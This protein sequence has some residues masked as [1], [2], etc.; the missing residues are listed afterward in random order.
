MWISIFM[1]R[2]VM[3]SFKGKHCSFFNEIQSGHPNNAFCHWNLEFL[4]TRF[5]FMD[6]FLR[7]MS[8]VKNRFQPPTTPVFAAPYHGV[9]YLHESRRY[10]TA[11]SVYTN[12]WPVTQRNHVLD[13]GLGKYPWKEWTRSLLELC[14]C[15][16]LP[17]RDPKAERIMAFSATEPNTKNSLTRLPTPGPAKSTKTSRVLTRL[18]YTARRWYTAFGK[19]DFPPSVAMVQRESPTP[20][21]RLRL[22]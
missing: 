10:N 16:G 5:F 14:F 20:C 17:E 22:T 1:S 21:R 13:K 2:K 4:M 19:R 3:M 8:S 11:K 6:R 7:Q 12:S 18:F 9:S 15:S